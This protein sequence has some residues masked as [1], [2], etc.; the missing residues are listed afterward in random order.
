MRPFLKIA[1]ALALVAAV[2]LPAAALLDTPYSVSV[3]ATTANATT[4][5]GF[6]AR[7]V[8]LYNTGSNTAYFS[9]DAAATSTAG[10]NVMILPANNPP[11]DYTFSKTGPTSVGIITGSST[12]TVLVYAFP[13]SGQ[14]AT[15]PASPANTFP[16][17][18]TFSGTATATTGLVSSGTLSVGTTSTFTGVATFTAQPILSSLTASRIMLT[19]SSKGPVSNGAITTNAVPK[20]ASSGASLS[21]SAISDDGTNITITEPLVGIT[22]EQGNYTTKALTSGAAATAYALVAVP[23]GTTAW[24]GVDY[25]YE[26]TDNTDFQARCGFIPVAAVNKG[27]T[28]TCTAGTVTTATE[29]VAV[30]TGTLTATNSCADGGSGNLQIKG[31]DTSSLTIGA[32]YN[33][34]R[35]RI[36]ALAPSTLTI[37]AQ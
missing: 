34:V 30:S 17:S 5:F 16:A 28:I 3:S 29:T 31:T 10:A 12:T 32:G 26:A 11:G 36:R 23:T 24:V 33:R 14:D 13:A 15:C 21:A 8:C 6:P 27:G 1:L 37:T 20:S 9:W 35:Y 4:S 2:A 18:P 25:C 19:D 22:L 7:H